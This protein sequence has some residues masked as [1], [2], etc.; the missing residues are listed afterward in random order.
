MASDALEFA[1]KVTGEEQV[2]AALQNI[3]N[4]LQTLEGAQSRT[5][6]ATE[7]LGGSFTSFKQGLGSVAVQ[8]NAIIAIFQ[9]VVGVI[10][11]VI[12]RVDETNDVMDAFSGNTKELTTRLGGMYRTLDVVKAS[13]IATQRGLNLTANEMQNVAIKARQVAEATGGDAV[14][15]MNQLTTALATGQTRGLKPFGITATTTRGQLKQL[16]EMVGDTAIEAHGLADAWDQAKN[17][18]GDAVDTMIDHFTNN[19]ELNR[20]VEEFSSAFKFNFRDLAEFAGKAVDYVVVRL[21]TVLQ[22]FEAVT[23]QLALAYAAGRTGNFDLMLQGLSSA[24]EQMGPRAVAARFAMNRYW[25]AHQ[26]FGQGG[27]NGPPTD[28]GRGGGGGGGENNAPEYLPNGTPIPTPEDLE[29][30]GSSGGGYTG[31]EGA[32]TYNYNGQALAYKELDKSKGSGDRKDAGIRKT[33]D[34]YAELAG[35]I[36]GDLVDAFELAAKGQKSFGAAIKDVIKNNLTAIAKEEAVLAIVETAKA[37]GSLAI[38]D[39]KGA[40]LHAASAAEH[41]AAA[42]AAGVGAAVVGSIGGG[43]GRGGSSVSVPT[44]RPSR[45]TSSGSGGEGN[46][47]NIFWNQPAMLAGTYADAG[48]L[49]VRSI[50]EYQQRYGM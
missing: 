37:L 31:P 17:A 46:V 18:A 19:S 33:I 49:I 9:K 50:T 16:N 22:T 27:G 6:T 7:S 15:A 39:P 25:T 14:Q 21:T 5:A 23:R 26:Q 43:G 34:E 1:L 2:A 28:T 30:A 13:N 35:V 41:A 48:R 32:P 3:A 29:A 8:A 47:V 45:D 42:A 24:L 38:P 40:A 12:E 4:R 11:D 20:A 36:G 10:G 44:E